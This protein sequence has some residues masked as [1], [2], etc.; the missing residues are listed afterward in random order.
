LGRDAISAL[1]Q[2][3][4]RQA[5]AKMQAAPESATFIC[6]DAAYSLTVAAQNDLASKVEAMRP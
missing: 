5:Q 3:K 1:Q 2:A 4:Q 6:V